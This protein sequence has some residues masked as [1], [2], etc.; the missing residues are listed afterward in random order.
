MYS[1]IEI[2][3]KDPMGWEYAVKNAIDEASENLR[4]LRIAAVK[5]L[6][7]KIDNGKISEYRVKIDLSFKD[8][9]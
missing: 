7:I 2:V 9:K 4:D 8:E 5:E 6:D 3:G 1:I